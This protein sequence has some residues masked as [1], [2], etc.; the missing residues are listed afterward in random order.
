MSLCHY[1]R[2]GDPKKDL[3][4]IVN[5]FALSTP[6]IVGNC[7]RKVAIKENYHFKEDFFFNKSKSL[8]YLPVSFSIDTSSAQ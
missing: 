7:K 1:L 3:L 2:A 4:H 8:K 6:S 5:Y